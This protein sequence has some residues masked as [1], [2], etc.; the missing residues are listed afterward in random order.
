MNRQ[1]EIKLPLMEQF[2]TL[3]GEGRFSGKPAVFIRLAGCDVG[4]VWCDVK[5]SWDAAAHSLVSIDKIV[6]DVLKTSCLFVVITGGEPTLYDL[7]DL[8]LKL[9]DSNIKVAIET[10]GTNELK[11]H[12]DWVT[13]SPKKFKKPLNEYYSNSNELKVVVYHLSDLDWAKE[14]AEKVKGNCEFFLQ[15]EWSKMDELMPAILA[16]VKLNPRWNLS[17][18]THKFIDIP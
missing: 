11:G 4:C 9:A 2:Y 13:F 8:T 6:E 16:F 15:P 3:Q 1:V 12:F 7:T 5:E 10:S 14:H 18:Q 17:L